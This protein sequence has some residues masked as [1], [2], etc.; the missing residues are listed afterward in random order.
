MPIPRAFGR[1][2]RDRAATVLALASLVGSGGCQDATAPLP[3]GASRFAPPP[4]Y[5]SWW[6]LVEA[7]SGRTGVFAAWAWY[8]VPDGA[9]RAAGYGNAA[10]YTDVA[11]RR[12]VMEEGLEANGS[13]IRHE[14]LHA[15]LG[16]AYA[17]GNS[18]QV[19]PPAYFQGRCAGVVWCD[20]GCADAGPPPPSAADGAPALPLSAL[21]VGINV[22][23]TGVSRTGTDRALTIVLHA[24]NPTAEP[25]WLALAPTLGVSPPSAHWWGFRIV[26]AGQSLPVTDLTRVDSTGIVFVIPAGRVPFAAGQTRWQVFDMSG[27]A[28]PPGDYQVVGIFNT[29]QIA[30]PLTITP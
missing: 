28:Y 4:V 3:S 15:L 22:I 26:P 9:L 27:G 1:R 20:Q 11:A 7:C 10:A 6:G 25:R 14:M 5:S 24:T 8:R 29:R 21:D 17:S 23:P 30:V 16:P 13:P 12:V 2:A 19:H 18:A